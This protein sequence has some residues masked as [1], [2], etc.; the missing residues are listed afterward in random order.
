M[1]S[2]D[3]AKALRD[4]GL[5]W[6]PKVGDLVDGLE[7][8][9]IVLGFKKEKCGFTFK[10]QDG[11]YGGN[12]WIWFP[13]LDQLLAEIEKC[14]YYPILEK[15]AHGTYEFIIRNENYEG[16]GGWQRDKSWEDVAANALLW[17]LKNEVKHHGKE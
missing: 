17:I 5:E 15:T 12:G 10:T 6:E 11:L 16:I 14:G 7:G 4:A 2:L 1:I 3:K 8:T 13:R 9:L